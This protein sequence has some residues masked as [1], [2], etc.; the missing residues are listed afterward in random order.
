VELDH[1]FILT[2]RGAPA[3]D[4]L[5]PLGF[6]EGAPNVHAG[7]GTACR[8]FFFANAYLEFLWVDDETEA[9]GEAM[10][11]TRLLE[12]WRA[13]ASGGSPFGIALR[14]RTP[15]EAPPFHTWDY[16]PPW[17]TEGA[18]PVAT[19]SERLDEPFLFVLPFGRRPERPGTARAS[20]RVV[21]DT[22]VAAPSAEAMAVAHH[23]LVAWRPADEH[24]ML[25]E[26]DRAAT[27]GHADLRPALPLQLRW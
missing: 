14:P 18:L 17:L 6:A 25:V 12:R 4:A 10:R 15:G 23:G 27:G 7:Q 8:R 22:P 11:R 5:I 16:R 19:N 9:A 26:F 20:T 13:R 3:A 21:L 24:G 1:L 2:D